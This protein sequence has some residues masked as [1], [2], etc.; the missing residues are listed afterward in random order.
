MWLLQASGKLLNLKTVKKGYPKWA[1]DTSGDP[2]SA[3]TCGTCHTVPSCELH[4]GKLGDISTLSNLCLGVLQRRGQALLT[5]VLASLLGEVGKR[6]PH[7]HTW[8]AC[9]SWLVMRACIAYIPIW[10]KHIVSARAWLINLPVLYCFVFHSWSI[11]NPHQQAG[12]QTG[13]S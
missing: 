1:G 10:S 12:E 3:L 5:L 11:I 4:I 7:S 6:L 9:D 8:Q 13:E 2:S